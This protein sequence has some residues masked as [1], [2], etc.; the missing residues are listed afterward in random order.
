MQLRY[1]RDRSNGAGGV[2]VL[3]QGPASPLAEY[4]G[5]Y[6]F[7][8]NGAPYRFNLVW[9]GVDASVNPELTAGRFTGAA[10]AVANVGDL[11]T[12]ATISVL[13]NGCLCG[14]L[15]GSRSRL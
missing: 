14:F 6:Q 15:G 11:W 13:T 3:K 2:S 10:F 7:K 12:S 1:L 9:A 5:A 4:N 8:L